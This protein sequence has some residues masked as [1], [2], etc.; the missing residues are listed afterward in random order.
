MLKIALLSLFILNNCSKNEQCTPQKIH[1]PKLPTYKTPKGREFKVKK[2]DEN[3]SII[4][5]D[6]LTE[7]VKNNDKLRAIC[8]K[9]CLINKKLNEVYNK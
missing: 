8:L 5:N 2:L 6:V 3:L 1:I 4:E 7:L 9:Y